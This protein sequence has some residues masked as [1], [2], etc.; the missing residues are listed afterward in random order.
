[1]TTKTIKAKPV[2]KPRARVAAPAPK[3]T[4][5][6]AAPALPAAEAPLPV[7]PEAPAAAVAAVAVDT[8]A[9]VETTPAIETLTAIEAPAATQKD[10]PMATK[11]ETINETLKTTATKAVE[12]GKAAFEQASAKAREAVE[13]GVAALEELNEFNRGNVEALVASGKAAAAG[14]ET[15]AQKATELSKKQVEDT[16][17]AVKTLAAA[18]T[19]NEFFQAHN[20]Y[21]KA[22]F[23]FAVGEMSRGAETMLKVMGEVFEPISN[24]VSLAVDKF[25]KAATVAR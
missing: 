12:Q 16:T 17:A 19:P 1:M 9:V 25:A 14:F 6:T 7:T 8:P 23:D 5:S 24:R 10:I 18:K 4:A 15:F 20:E 22:Q 21:A 2:R 13:K 11:V 3:V